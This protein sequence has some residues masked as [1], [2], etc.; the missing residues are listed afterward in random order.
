M[1][2]GL[3]K[4][5]EIARRAGVTTASI[6]FYVKEGILPRPQKTSRNMAY[7]EASY[8]DHIRII[9]ELQ[10]KRYIPL[11]VIKRIMKGKNLEQF[12]ALKS[13]LSAQGEVFKAL[14]F[15]VRLS[16]I[17]REELIRQTGIAEADLADAERMGMVEPVKGFYGEDDIL[18]AEAGADLRRKGFTE[19]L[20]FKVRDLEF[21]IK[22]AER[23]VKDEMKLFST[24]R[25]EK[26]FNE[27]SADLVRSGIQIINSLFSVLNRKFVKRV[28]LE[29]TEKFRSL[30]GS[31][32]A[33][34]GRQAERDGNR[35]P[36]KTAHRRAAARG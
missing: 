21:V 6:K 30:S 34:A 33:A 10:T 17:G 35:A 31:G 9:K 25:G 12:V 5:G 4:I 27:E 22:A 14:T 1:P 13:L 3:Y 16:P 28:V 11:R 19:K 26:I 7:Y 29:V 2:A 20:G 8:I 36:G 18:V 23:M 32:Q 24:R 15:P